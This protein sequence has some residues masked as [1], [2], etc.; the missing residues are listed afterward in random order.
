MILSEI[1]GIKYPVIQGGMANIATG[2][3]AAAISNAGALGVIGSGAM[4]PE[5]VKRE[6]EIC[7]GLTDKPFGLNIM[8][9]SPYSDEISQ[10]AID[11]KISVVTTG[12]GNPG[13]YIEE[14]KKAGV[15]V[16]PVVSSQAL[17]IKME[18]EGVDG[19]IAEGM[20]AGGHIG[21]M[22][23]M[24]LVPQVKSA[25]KIPVIAA[26]GVAS[27]SQLLA[28]EVLGASGVQLGTLLLVSDECPAHDNFKDVIVKSG[29]NKVTVIG[30]IGGVAT[31]VVKNKMTRDY[32]AKEKE[33]W[34]KHQLE[35]FTLGALRRA[36]M[37][38]DVQ[39][40][41]IMAGLD[42]GQV[43]ERNCVSYILD[44]LMDEYEM[45]KEKLCKN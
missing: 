1:L 36:V 10:I 31:R 42:I 32:L 28:A 13:K 33:G 7:K 12:A 39:E 35:K 27:G 16:F 24:T 43:N 11:Y 3:F 15:K 40:G 20:E 45:E 4:T 23:T 5:V 22:T 6:I 25:V 37:D 8:L 18:R 2:E 29:S 30:R 38:G 44:K 19:I 34:D 9:M 26:G 21:E 41:S 14:W 17:A